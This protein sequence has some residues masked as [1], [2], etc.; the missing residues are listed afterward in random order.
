MIWFWHLASRN[1]IGEPFDSSCCSMEWLT[2]K[3][4]QRTHGQEHTCGMTGTTLNPLSGVGQNVNLWKRPRIGTN[5]SAPSLFPSSFDDIPQ[6]FF[7]HT[8]IA[9]TSPYKYG[10]FYATA[11]RVMIQ[12]LSL[13]NHL[14]KFLVGSW[15]WSFSFSFL[16]GVGLATP[17]DKQPRY[18]E[19]MGQYIPEAL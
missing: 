10:Q 5:A 16:R 12:N 3:A 13:L 19:K 9:P 15:I 11:N 8:N 18:N 2:Y 7:R 4:L 17:P 14:N 1:T 6:S